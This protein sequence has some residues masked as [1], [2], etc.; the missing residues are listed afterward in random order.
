M[1]IYFFHYLVC[2]S[3]EVWIVLLSKMG[4]HLNYGQT[5]T[6][7]L[8]CCHEVLALLCPDLSPGA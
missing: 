3:F 7:L 6:S 2:V 5:L 1:F 8:R 4:W